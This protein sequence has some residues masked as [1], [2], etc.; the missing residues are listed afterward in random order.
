M[1][2]LLISAVFMCA[3]LLP[4]RAYGLDPFEIQ[5]YD[6]TANAPL[7][8]GV[9]LHA[10]RV[11]N[12]A[13]SAEAPLA[14]PNHQSHFTLEASFGLTAWWELGAYFQTALLGDGTFAYAGTKLRSKFVT[15]PGWQEHLRLGINVEFSFVPQRFDASVQGAELRPVIAWENPSWLFAANPIIEFALGHPGWQEGPGFSPALM[16]LYKWQDKLAFGFEYYANLGAFADGFLP[17]Q[18]QE[19]YLFEAI[20]VTCIPHTE[21]NFGIGEGLTAASSGLVMK[22][23]VGY[24]WEHDASPELAAMRPGSSR[25]YSRLR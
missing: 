20:N 8:P 17:V 11:F 23:I 6:G 16:A 12:G 10:N 13:R 9:E 24:E 21:F 14:A 19:H 4:A 18:S 5:V 2:R 25:S 15:P 22:L 3:G 7:S 1:R